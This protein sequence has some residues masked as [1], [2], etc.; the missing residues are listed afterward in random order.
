MK[1]AISVILFWVCMSTLFAQQISVKTFRK[2]ET[3]L[4]ARVSEPLKDQNGDWCAII[5]VQTT[6]SGFYFDGGQLGIVKTVP[7]HGEIWVYVPWGLKRL[8][9]SHDKLGVL[10]DYALNIPIEKATVYELV[11]VSGRLET[12]V[13]EEIT[14]QWLVITPQPD[15]AM[16]Y[17]DDIFVSKGEY[18]AQRVPGKYNYRVEAPLFHTEAGMLEITDGKKELKVNLKPAYGNIDLTTTP[19]S[20]ASVLIDGK[21]QTKITPCLSENLASGEHTVQVIKDM[22]QPLTK[23]ALVTDGHITALKIN[24]TPNFAELNLT[25]PINANII[26]NGQI[27]GKGTWSGRLSAGVYSI[28]AQQEKYRSAKQDIELSIGDSKKLSLQPTPIY[29]S[30]NIVTSPSGAS[31]LINGKDYGTTPNSLNKLLIGEYSVQLTKSGY[32]SVNKTVAITDGKSAELVETMAKVQL[33]GSS[34]NVKTKPVFKNDVDSMSYILGFIGGTELAEKLKVILGS[35][36]N[37]DLMIL[38][39]STAIKKEKGLIYNELSQEYFEKYFESYCEEAKIENKLSDK[40]MKIKSTSSSLNNSVDSMSYCIGIY[41]GTQFISTL[42]YIP[43][44]KSNI[45]LIIK[46]FSTAM[47]GHSTLI[48]PEIAKEFLINYITTKD[49]ELNI[50]VGEKFLAENK[51][52]KSVT[53]TSSGLQYEILIPK[54]GPKPAATDTVKLHYIGTLV[55][56]T[57]FDSS[58]DRGDSI[59]FALNQVIPGWTEGVQLMSV[60][61]K[62]KFVIPYNLGYGEKGSGPIPAYST[63]IFEVE[64][65]EIKRKK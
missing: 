32:A 5:K 42:K 57:K 30:I 54:D 51:V 53:T 27:K 17:I 44:G 23:K 20:G 28:E 31:I 9:I 26:I 52:K 49:G 58:I 21:E 61:S 19:E 34:R 62:Y 4:D 14:K 63:L 2:L 64:L 37:K 60:G 16:I 8:T 46:G 65:L 39:F 11:L 22:Y 7:K 1:K 48:N 6:Q 29:G 41:L 3:D 35:K 59:S 18:Q 36:V 13:I 45:D 25:A 38:G 15:K 50:A 56:G 33:V 55:D 47:I 43:G 24:L 40:N 12:T 10:R